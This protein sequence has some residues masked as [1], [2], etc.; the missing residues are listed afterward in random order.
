MQAGIMSCRS[1]GRNPPHRFSRDHA[2]VA[3]LGWMI[4][5]VVA[6]SMTKGSARIERGTANS[7]GPQSADWRPAGD[8]SMVCLV[9]SW[10]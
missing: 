8:A 4:G 2:L 5:L 9:Q 7:S 10:D 3:D 6:R 1:T